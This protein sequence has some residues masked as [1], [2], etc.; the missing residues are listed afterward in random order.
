MSKK[1]KDEIEEAKTKYN[2]GEFEEA[3]TIF[4][5]LA[6]NSMEAAY[7]L[8]DI[9]LHGY[10][11]K[12]DYHQ[13]YKYFKQAAD[14]DYPDA[15]A[16][17]GAMY[18]NGQLVEKDIEKGISLVRQA[19]A[20]GSG[21]AFDTLGMLYESGT[22]VEKSDEM[23][24][25]YYQKSADKGNL[26][27]MYNLGRKYFFGQ[28]VEENAVKAFELIGDAQAKPEASYLL[29]MM[30]YKEIGFCSDKAMAIDLLQYSSNMEC[31]AAQCQL[32]SMYL[33]GILV[34]KNVQKGMELLMKAEANGNKKAK[35]ILQKIKG[36]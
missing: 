32:G 24:V 14:N 5:T 18:I 11:T 13:A 28:G 34:E 17:L 16:S 7:Y 31:A 22:G 19:E 20:T 35:S 4:A 30:H 33:Q 25:S 29:G 1:F 2:T 12:K 36:E 8:G 21:V 9:Y 23:A 6:K 26:S 15:I 27:G 10:G 3:K